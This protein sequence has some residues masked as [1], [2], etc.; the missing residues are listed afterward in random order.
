M[1]EKTITARIVLTTT[2][3]LGDARNLGRQLVE[4]QLAACAN[5]IP[6]VESIYRWQGK[7]EDSNEVLLLLK[8]TEEKLEDLESRLN[9]LHK[10]QTPEFLVLDIECGSSKYLKWLTESL[11]LPRNG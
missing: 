1:L 11:S 7:I 6:A 3:T 9:S 2:E 10:Y 4:E 5:V 8:T